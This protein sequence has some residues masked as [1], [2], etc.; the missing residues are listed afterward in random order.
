MREVFVRLRAAGLTVNPDKVKFPSD[1]LSFSGHKISYQ[2]VT[3]DLSRT[4]AILDFPIPSSVKEIARFVGMIN[5]FHKLIPNLADTAAPLNALPKKG[6]EFVWGQSQ[7]L[8]FD[9][10]KHKITSP[11][12]LVVPDFSKRFILQ[13]DASPVA[14]GAVL[15]QDMPEGCRAVSYASRTLTAQER[16]YSVFELEAL[17]VLFGT[18]KFRVHFEHVSFDLETDC[19][20]LSWVLAKPRTMGRIARWAVRLSAFKFSARHIRDSDNSIADALSQMFSDDS[21]LEGEESK[22]SPAVC[23]GLFQVDSFSWFLVSEIPIAFQSPCEHQREM[24]KLLPKIT[25]LEGGKDVP[26][27]CLR[28]KILYSLVGQSRSLRIVLPRTMVDLV[29][30]FFHESPIGGYLG[31]FKTRNKIRQYFVWCEMDTDIRVRIKTCRVCAVAKP[32]QKANFGFLSLEV[33]RAP[34]DRLVIDCRQVSAL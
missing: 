7:Q 5:Y 2:G 20:A 17:A 12:I 14:L 21:G 1:Q 8:A 13:T 24:K 10:L 27:F 18:E 31:I 4:K 6:V 25:D 11:P 15:K 32:A 29:F 33:H 19:Q 3:I 23:S 30:H 28:N 34:L 16:K 22:E 9:S 26:G